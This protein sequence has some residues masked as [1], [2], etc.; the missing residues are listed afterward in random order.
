MY[1]SALVVPSTVVPRSTWYRRTPDSASVLAV[2]VSTG[3][4]FVGVVALTAEGVVGAVVSYATGN[5]VDAALSRFV[6]VST[7][8]TV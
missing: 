8:F 6:P 3:A 5:A 1:V 2:Q 4:A 7:A